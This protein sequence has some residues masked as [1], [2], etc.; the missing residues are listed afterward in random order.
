M[1]V[2][3][4][5][6]NAV[7]RLGGET[8]ERVTGLSDDN[9]PVELPEVT[10]SEQTYGPDGTM[11]AQAT[12][13]QGGEVKVK[14]LPVS[15]TVARWLGIY[16]S[17]LKGTRVV[18]NGSYTHHIVVVSDSGSRRHEAT[19]TFRGGVLKMATPGVVPGVNNIFTFEFE[20]II[21]DASLWNPT[22]A[23]SLAG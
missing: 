21:P 15:P 7:L 2:F 3:I 9:P 10:L 16:A 8:I 13:R 5:H 14:L 1:P 19:V 22:T 4:D 6:N 20:Q 12:G 17:I 11:Y 23:P 18:W